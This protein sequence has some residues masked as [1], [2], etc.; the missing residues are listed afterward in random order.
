MARNFDKL[1][2][3]RFGIAHLTFPNNKDVPSERFQLLSVLLVPTPVFLKLR[4]PIFD[5]GLW[6]M[7]IDALPMLMPETT[8]N[9]NYFS[10]V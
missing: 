7:R 10:S 9:V 8:A 2:V 3:I 1:R 6:D 5:T 4:T